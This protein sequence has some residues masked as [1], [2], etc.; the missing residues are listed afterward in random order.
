MKKLSYI[1]VLTLISGMLLGG[2]ASVS[3]EDFAAVQSTAEQAATDAA[4]AKAMA[5]DAQAE[6]QAAKARADA[7]E[8][9]AAETESKIDRMFKKSMYK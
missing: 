9:K 5:A 2:C 4:E 7:A 1:L 8:A 3:K 6:A